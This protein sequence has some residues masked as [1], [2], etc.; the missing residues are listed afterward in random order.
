MEPDQETVD[1]A[2]EVGLRL[3]DSAAELSMR[4]FAD[5]ASL[6][7]STKPDG[8]L[9]TEADL[10]VED[11]LRT[12]LG[13]V[14]PGDGMLGEERGHTG[15]ASQY[16]VIDAID[17]TSSFASG[18][19][20][21]GTMIAFC[22]EGQ[23]LVGIADQPVVRRRC[24]AAAGRGAWSRENRAERRLEVSDRTWDG[25]RV[26]RTPGDAPAPAAAGWSR[27]LQATCLVPNTD[28]PALQVAAGNCEIAVVFGGAWDLAATAMIVA[29]AGGSWSDLDGNSLIDSGAVLYTNGR[30]HD[31]IVGMLAST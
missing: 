22:S 2:L 18:G 24:W 4:A 19:T 11:E 21:W 13:A 5:V 20:Y 30:V 28:H 25:A 31:R 8:T 29:E 1:A 10:M 14:R 27:L 16:W 23:L 7:S 26:L 15:P 17:G 3:A 12:I 6:K 9:V